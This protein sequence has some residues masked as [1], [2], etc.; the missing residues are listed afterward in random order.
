MQ[1]W[2]RVM[3]AY[4]LAKIAFAY[5]Q[6]KRSS[7][8]RYFEHPKAVALIGLLEF[9]E[10]DPDSIIVDLLHDI[11]EDTHF[12][13]DYIECT[14]G[15]RVATACDLVT[16]LPKEL[17]KT[18]HRKT[19]HY[20]G[21]AESDLA[22]KTKVRDRLH[23]NRTSNENCGVTKEKAQ[24]KLKETENYIVPIAKSLPDPI[25]LEKLEES[26]RL[27]QKRYNN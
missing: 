12:T 10:S 16:N 3:S 20:Q 2:F 5:N 1:Y 19:N 8:E 26:M 13:T 21:I 17:M 27:M 24:R 11:V 25:Y 7:G 22:A 14:Y 15:K 4:H 18:P 23:N 6:K 9:D